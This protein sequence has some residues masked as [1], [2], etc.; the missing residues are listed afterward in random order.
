MD[1]SSSAEVQVCWSC[2]HE[3]LRHLA[4]ILSRARESEAE[5]HMSLCPARLLNGLIPY[6]SVARPRRQRWEQVW[7]RYVNSTIAASGGI[8]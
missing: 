6:R 5:C 7:V 8:M 2:E 1:V 3:V 4:S